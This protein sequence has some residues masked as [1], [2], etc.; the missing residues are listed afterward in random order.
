MPHIS[1][2]HLPAPLTDEQTTAL[3]DA[4]SDAVRTA[5]AV[6]D[7]VISI[8]VEAVPKDEWHEAVYLPEIVNRAGLLRKKPNY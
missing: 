5:F 2:K 7:D 1:I 4:V 8:A 3:V 6:P